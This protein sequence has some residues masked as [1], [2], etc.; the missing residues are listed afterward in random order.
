MSQLFTSF[1]VSENKCCC[2]DTAVDR[3]VNNVDQPFVDT[4]LSVHGLGDLC[5]DRRVQ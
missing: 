3:L 4:P 5:E 2:A 1:F